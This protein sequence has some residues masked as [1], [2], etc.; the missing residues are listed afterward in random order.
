MDKEG[1]K[2]ERKKK[3]K[4]RRRKERGKEK[5]R[6]RGIYSGGSLNDKVLFSKKEGSLESG[7]RER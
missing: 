3:G 7:I 1:K 5:K 6:R 2:G 4:G